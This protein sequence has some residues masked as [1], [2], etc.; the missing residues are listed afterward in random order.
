[1]YI[2]SFW[3]YEGTKLQLKR[4]EAIVG[5]FFESHI[6]SHSP[7]IWPKEG[8][9]GRANPGERNARQQSHQ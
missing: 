3:T 2:I 8:V 7:I 6:I 9:Y 1:V 4:M 5:F